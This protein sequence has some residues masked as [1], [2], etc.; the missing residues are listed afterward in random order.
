MHLIAI[1]GPRG[2]GKD[3]IENALLSHFSSLR[4]VVSFTTRAPR[5]GEV[6]GH[7][8]YFISNKE[9]DV[10]IRTDQLLCW[11]NIGPSQRSGMTRDEFE[12]IRI[13]NLICEAT[14]YLDRIARDHVTTMGAKTLLIAVLAPEENC[15]DRIKKRQPDIT[16]AEVEQLIK[17]DPVPSDSQSFS[18]FDLII[19]NEGRDPQPAIQLA[20]SR[21]N[22]FLT[23]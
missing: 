3:T 23:M 1:G 17:E 5:P 18:D 2:A 16:E 10:L 7:D 22:E 14:P 8:Y 9:F 12:R 13:H 19:R 15:R 21:V 6:E 4:P 11:Q 20:I